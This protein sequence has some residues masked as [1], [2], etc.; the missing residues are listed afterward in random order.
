MRRSFEKALR[1][2]GFSRKPGG[3]ARNF[4][5]VDERAREVDVHAVDIDPRGYAFFALPDGRVWPFPPAAFAGRGTVAGRE[6]RCLSP[7]AQVQC[8]GQGYEPAESDLQ[9]M[10]RLQERFGV[11]LPIHLCRQR[12]VR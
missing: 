8:H 1:A 2:L 10:E 7:D 4:V 12:E 9:D 3:T 6:V 11:V 5:L